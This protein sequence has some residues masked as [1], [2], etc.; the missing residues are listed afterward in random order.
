MF[1]FEG[2][3]LGSA[4]KQETAPEEPLREPTPEEIQE[5]LRE[6]LLNNVSLPTREEITASLDDHDTWER[7]YFKTREPVFE[8]LN[9][10]YMSAFAN[11]IIKRIGK[12][13]TIEKPVVIL[14]IAAGDGRLSH[15]L[16]EKLDEKIPGKVKVYAT[17]IRTPKPDSGLTVEEF[18][19]DE[20]LKAH[21]PQI[22]ICSWMPPKVDL[23]KEI[24][25]TESVQEYILIGESGIDGSCGK[26]WETWGH[27]PVFQEPEEEKD[28]PFVED[29]FTQEDLRKLSVLQICRSDD[30][31]HYFHSSTVSFKRKD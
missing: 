30:P 31:G 20:A 4:T 23:T 19:H 2:F 12:E 17:D 24:R 7:F 9:E 11:Y 26:N 28:P 6:K 16:Q 29:G 21:E 27:K 25:E 8:L 1:G 3:S 14:E 18:E 5:G 22:V 13:A 15:F 10:E